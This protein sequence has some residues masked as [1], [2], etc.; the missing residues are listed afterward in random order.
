M[1]DAQSPLPSFLITVPGGRNA[2][3]DEDNLGH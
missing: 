1:K 3:T 2:T